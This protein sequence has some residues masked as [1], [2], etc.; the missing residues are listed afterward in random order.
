MQSYESEYI[1]QVLNGDAG[2]RLLCSK[3]PAL[4][5]SFFYKTFR[6]EHKHIILSEQFEV[7][8]ADYI[9]MQA[10]NGS[11]IIIDSSEEENANELTV[12]TAE[13]RAHFL[14]NKWCSDEIAY[15]RRYH[16]DRREPVVELSASVDR[17]LTWLENMNAQTFVGTESRFQDILHKLQ[18]LAENATQNTEKRIEELK[19]RKADIEVQLKKIKETGKAEIYT[20]V[21]LMERLSEVSRASR[22][23]LTDFKQ[24]EE[25]FKVILADI[26]KKQATQSSKGEIL[27]YALDANH[28]MNETPQGQSFTAFW[29]FLAADAGKN[30][31]NTL[32]RTILEQT[33]RLGIKWT[34]KS[35]LHLKKDLQ[36]AGGKIISENHTLAGKLNRVLLSQ[37]ISEHK[38]LMELISEIKNKCFQLADNPPDESSFMWTQT[39]ALLNFPQARQ[40]TLPQITE[41]FEALSS[42]DNETV[43]EL[44]ANSGIF[45]QFYVD[46]Q[47]LQQKIDTYRNMYSGQQFSLM[48]LL[49]KFP[50]EKGL[51][52]ILTYFSLASKQNA[53]SIIENATETISYLRDD[54]RV[55][56]R[57][58]K[59]I[60]V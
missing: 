36:N 34:D 27:G 39:K 10:E 41:E 48:Q 59:L 55:E 57:I 5:I 54:K 43:H 2:I 24:V 35:L 30:Q 50:L 19:K 12:K 15:I 8:L 52:E 47:L 23:L 40:M 28:E 58:P 29:R 20:P 6:E 49:E 18:E 44:I 25:N 11:N 17:V 32:T 22:E 60:F 13:A 16:N 42:F 38:R 53:T 56:I 45:N 26:Y 46:E 1:A 4:I 31:I 51:A 7:L 9:R 37:N 21:Q 3:N 14:V 33:S